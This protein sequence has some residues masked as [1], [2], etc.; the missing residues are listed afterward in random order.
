MSDFWFL[1][2]NCFH[3]FW[4]QGY[5]WIFCEDLEWNSGSISRPSCGSLGVWRSHGE[6]YT[7]CFSVCIT[8][9]YLADKRWK[10]N[11]FI[12]TGQPSEN[13]CFGLKSKAQDKFLAGFT[14]L[15]CVCLFLDGTHCSSLVP[16]ALCIDGVKKY[17]LNAPDNRTRWLSALKHLIH[18]SV[19]HLYIFNHFIWNTSIFFHARTVCVCL[20]VGLSTYKSCL[21]Y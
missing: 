6:S 17:S 12:F 18:S 16:R 11:I 15:L 9:F 2:C 7:I 10:D 5:L 8:D 21:C 19:H 14:P 3:P 20:Y 13:I 1:S 4:P